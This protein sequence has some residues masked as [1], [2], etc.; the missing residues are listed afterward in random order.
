MASRTTCSRPGAVA[1]QPVRD[2]LERVQRPE[3]AQHLAAQHDQPAVLEHA[4]LAAVLGLVRRRRLL[5][6]V[7]RRLVDGAP[8]A[9]HHQ[10]RQRQVVPEA[11]VDLDVVAAAHGVDRAVAARDRAEP[12][13]G[14]AHAHLVAPVEAFAVRAV[15]LQ[16]LQLAAD[17]RDVGIGEDADELP[18][19]VGRPRRVR[20]REGHDLAV[21]LADGP[22]LR[23]H[24]AAARVRDHDDARVLQGDLLGAVGRRIG[25]DDD[26]QLVLRVVELEQVLDRAARS[27]S[28]RCTPRRSRS[29][30]AP[31]RRREPCAERN[32]RGAAA[33]AGYATWVQT[34]AAEARPR[35]RSRQTITDADSTL[36]GVTRARTLEFALL[37]GV[38]AAQGFLFTRTLHA[39]NE[40]RRGRLPRG[41]RR[42]P[43]R[44]GPRHGR[45]RGAVPRLLRPAARPVLR[46]R[47]RGGRSCARHCSA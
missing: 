46:R 6:R 9:L 43:P 8:P 24:L 34:S 38:L 21:G 37:A 33:N 25:R 20:I 27:R 4:H 30:T 44:A 11:R 16:D 40:L 23:G 28:P 32:G 14:A 7:R 35:S 39:A 45:L 31:G 42:A 18:Q 41:R 17:V 19:R 12:R 3:P 2:D 22:V 26:L 29:R 47:H 10:V 1:E 36:G 15:G 5:P 13:L